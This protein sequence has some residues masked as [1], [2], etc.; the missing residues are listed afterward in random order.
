MKEKQKTRKS[1]K[2]QKEELEYYKLNYKSH[3]QEILKY[4]SIIKSLTD[5]NN[6][7]QEI[8]LKNSNENNKKNNEQN[9]ICYSIKDFKNLWRT[10]TEVELIDKFDFC[11]DEY[12]LIANISQDI[13][14]LVYDLAK[15]LINIKFNEILR[16]LNLDKK[17]DT[18]HKQLFD[19]FL[20]VFQENLKDIFINSENSLNILMIKLEKIV[21]NYDTDQII[22]NKDKKYKSILLNEVIKKI[23]NHHFDELMKYFLNICIYMLLHSPIL[24]FDIQE[25]SKR[26]II[27]CFFDKNNFTAIEGFPNDKSPCIILLPP[28]LLKNKYPFANLHY[29]VYIIE[30]PTKDIISQCQIV[31][32]NN[33]T[34]DKSNLYNFSNI[35][36]Y[37]DFKHNIN[38]NVI[39]NKT[40]KKLNSKN[41]KIE[42]CKT[43]RI[44]RVTPK[45]K[46]KFKLKSAKV[47]KTNEYFVNKIIKPLKNQTMVKTKIK[48]QNK[49]TNTNKNLLII[50]NS[51]DNIKKKQN[52]QNF[53]FL[54]KEFNNKNFIYT[55]NCNIK[56]SPLKKMKNTNS[57]CNSSS[58]KHNKKKDFQCKNVGYIQN[59]SSKN[60]KI[61]F[62]GH[63]NRIMNANGSN[64]N[65]NYNYYN[66]SISGLKSNNY[67]INNYT[68]NNTTNT[69]YSYA[70]NLNLLNSKENLISQKSDQNNMYI[71]YDLFL[72]KRSSTLK[73][74][75]SFNKINNSKKINQNEGRKTFN[76][77][78]NNFNSNYS[79][80]SNET[81]NKII[82]YNL[83]NVSNNTN[84]V[85]LNYKKISLYNLNLRNKKLQKH[86]N[87]GS[88]EKIQN[89]NSKNFNK[90]CNPFYN[91]TFSHFNNTSLYN[92]QTFINNN[93]KKYLCNSSCNNNKIICFLKYNIKNNNIS[94]NYNKKKVYSDVNKAL[95][96]QQNLKK[97]KIKN[98]K[99]ADRTKFSY[100]TKI[101]ASNNE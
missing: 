64:V 77:T 17:T 21:R 11:L 40:N 49:N 46:D 30:S 92:T 13:L 48:E 27:Y 97:I 62:N 71:N 33:K 56:K 81:K 45:N 63:I 29:A 84:S 43:Q 53:Q 72:S 83:N 10:V 54:T 68:Y 101:K 80:N 70:N 1:F 86:L 8:L 96:K 87:E 99:F 19:N 4:E 91:S 38:T 69:T 76:E 73:K 24:S 94:N 6:K 65:N 12:K 2:N 100:L 60:N 95:Q 66:H 3:M 36:S 93:E 23:K 26:K 42:N 85:K 41:K 16:C 25:Y 75:L 34:F 37:N 5:S 55:S 9:Q 22:I 57:K 78:T 44:N 58:K 88:K 28:P 98:K 82:N 35:N 89:Y 51:T 52:K 18:Q 67:N 32:T 59:I 31:K 39:F 90:S 7:L 79:C 74:Q 20:P 47:G 15:N 50:N 61:N 14:L